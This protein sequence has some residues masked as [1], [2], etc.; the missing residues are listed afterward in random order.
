MKAVTIYP[1]FD[2]FN[3]SFY[4]NCLVEVFGA[5]NIHFTTEGF[6][7]FK[8]SGSLKA[9]IQDGEQRTRIFVDHWDLPIF[10][11]E[12]LEWCNVY[13]K[14]NIDPNSIPAK[15]ADK[16]VP[17][18]PSFPVRA[19]NAGLGAY[20]AFSTFWQSYRGSLL[21]GGP[22]GERTRLHF[23]NWCRQL[24]TRLNVDTYKPG[25][26][27]SDYVFFCCSLW[28]RDGAANDARATF[29]RACK[30]MPG[31]TF[32]GGFARRDDIDVHKDLMVDKWYTQRQFVKKTIASVVVFNNPA[33]SSCHSWRLGEYLALGKAI[34]SLP[35]K[36]ML[37]A[38]LV[39]GQHI[40][41]VDQSIDSIGKAIQVISRDAAYKD[42]LEK[43]AREY[44][45]RYLSP[46]AIVE[47]LGG[48]P[49]SCRNSRAG[50]NAV[51]LS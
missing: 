24:I 2:V 13:A 10:D 27:S 35:I 29:I 8:S 41:Y 30:S 7:T 6:P 46:A 18:G 47:L 50:H 3:Q 45:M 5:R 38:S 28:K 39:H 9:I 43:G 40:H 49:L 23:T 14:R 20:Y 37:P 31:M 11:E 44:Y 21:R 51:L 17:A 25:R 36:R 12:A 22:T 32:E 4:L 26:S 19:C 48:S 16:I 42:Q 33:V 34:I 1:C 15:Y